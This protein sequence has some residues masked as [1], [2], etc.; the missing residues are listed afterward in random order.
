MEEQNPGEF[1]GGIEVG[2]VDSGSTISGK[3]DE[4]LERGV[5]RSQV[6]EVGWVLGVFVSRVGRGSF[7]PSLPLL[8]LILVRQHFTFGSVRLSP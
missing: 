8:L 5:E 2:P 6:S 7:L 4:G 3:E 1:P